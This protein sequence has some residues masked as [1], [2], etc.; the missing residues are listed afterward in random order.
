MVAV[1][2]VDVLQGAC[3]FVVAILAA[4][5]GCAGLD[6]VCDSET[7]DARNLRGCGFDGGARKKV[8]LVAK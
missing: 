8:L 3:G 4:S 5:D 7:R 1:L 6:I 2:G